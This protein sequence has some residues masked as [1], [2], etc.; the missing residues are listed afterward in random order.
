MPREKSNNDFPLSF[1]VP[2][3]W[4]QLA[5]ELAGAMSKHPVQITRTDVV[6]TALL[7]GLEALRAEHLKTS[8]GGK[9]K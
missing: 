9:K 3:D 8:A 7:R 1:K 5:D 6:R 4:V 2:E